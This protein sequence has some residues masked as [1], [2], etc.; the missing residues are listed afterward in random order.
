MSTDSK[1]PKNT[2]FQN[3]MSE[4]I[5]DIKRRSYIKDCFCDNENCNGSIISAHS[6]QNN[7]ILKKLS[8]NGEVV[9]LS[10]RDRVYEADSDGVSFSLSETKTTGRGKATTFTGFCK[11][12]DNEIFKPIELYDYRLKNIE[13]EFLF[14]YRALAKEYYSKRI[15]TN[16]TNILLQEPSEKK[17]KFLTFFEQLQLNID[18][19]SN[20]IL[21]QNLEKEK[22]FFNKILAEKTFSKLVT[23][24]IVFDQE[25]HLS[26][27]CC[28]GP[29]QD[30]YGNPINKY[31]RLEEGLKNIYLTI[32]PQNGKTYILFSYLRK[33][34]S[35]LYRLIDQI[36]KPKEIPKKQII[37]SNILASS[38][39]NVV[40]SPVRWSEVSDPQRKVFYDVFKST[41]RTVNWD[42]QKPHDINLFI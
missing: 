26:A 19:R 16:F 32:F 4:W 21:I 23:K 27:C 13:Q 39:E 17:N 30:L 35:R 12:H 9:S 24:A 29:E 5:E 15:S 22:S 33:N 28:F 6:I 11:Y 31:P 7:K 37:I 1:N 10:S 25:Y 41:F 3:E 38:C 14:A 42:L 8:R 40:L 36:N 2:N 34:S 20:I 18:L